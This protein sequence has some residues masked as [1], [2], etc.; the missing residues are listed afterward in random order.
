MADVVCFGELM[1]RLTP[2]GYQRLSQAHVLEKGFGGAEANVAV[3]L[4][5]FGDTAAFVTRLPN[6]AL[7]D[8]AIGELR[9]YGVDTSLIVRGGNR[10]GIYFIE[11]GASQRPSTVLYDRADSAIA[12][13]TEDEFDWERILTGAK[14]FH[15]TGI[16]PALSES[17]AANCLQAVKT[18]RRLGLKVSCDLNY[19]K[20]L[21]TSERAGEI[22][23]PLMRHTDLC[24]ANEE[25]AEQ[26]FGIRA[27]DSDVGSGTL[28]EDGY[29]EV[30]AELTRRFSLSMV[31]ITLRRSFS[32]TDNEWGGMLYDG[33]EAFFSRKYP[34]HL[35]DRVGG[36]D[37]FGAGLIH[38]LLRGRGKAEA[39]EFAVAA[40]CLKQ[41]I[42]G[43]FNNVSVAEVEALAGGDLSGRVVR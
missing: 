8:A 12:T 3:S 26:V 40:S 34:I 2:P 1:L 33:E 20:K 31:A 19:R 39:L 29:R 16:T 27:R 25:D 23:D 30:A 35:V 37:A 36:G 28:S 21:W 24:L 7:G 10:I 42:E 38:S 32:A 4:S 17:A 18:A 15:F 14:W 43:D 13:C 41:T 9:R 11:K 22:M 5:R 6:H